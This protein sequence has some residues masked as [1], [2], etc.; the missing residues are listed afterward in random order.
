M[1]YEDHINDIKKPE[2]TGFLHCLF[3]VII[4]Q[5]EQYPD[6]HLLWEQFQSFQPEYWQHLG[7]GMQEV[8]DPDE[9]S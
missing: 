6:P 5:A 8:W 4:R 7:I 9:Y 2:Y 3:F 1:N